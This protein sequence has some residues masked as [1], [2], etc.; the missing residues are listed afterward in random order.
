M[1]RVAIITGYATYQG[2]LELNAT[3]GQQVRFL[4]ALNFP[5]RLVHGGSPAAPTLLL[6][7]AVRR[8]D[9]TGAVTACGPVVTL[10]PATIIA[11]YEV[12]GGQKRGGDA[13]ATAY[14]QR[15][16]QQE[17]TTRVQVFLD[18]GVRLEASVAGGV[19]S[20]DAARPQG[21]GDFVACIEVV[22]SDPRRN[23]TRQVP[24]MALNARRIEAGGLMPE[25]AAA[26]PAASE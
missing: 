3:S 9:V 18:N 17:E 22:M 12:G 13:A 14:E 15:R 7:D 6:R 8:D 26:T 11:G 4:D 24:F 23:G 2:E 21:R 5:H 16:H 20:L 19:Q 25:T 1:A 10:R